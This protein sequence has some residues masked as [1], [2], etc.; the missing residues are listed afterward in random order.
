MLRRF[1]YFVIVL[2][3]AILI[4]AVWISHEIT[5]LGD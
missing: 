1:E 5:K 3:A 4:G 2:A